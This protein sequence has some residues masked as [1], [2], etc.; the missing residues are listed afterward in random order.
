MEIILYLI[1]A[2]PETQNLLMPHV[3]TFLCREIPSLVKFLKP[4]YFCTAADL[5]QPVD[6]GWL[7][8]Q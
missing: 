4:R 1:M 7:E 6:R 8:C 2:E 5:L 3:V